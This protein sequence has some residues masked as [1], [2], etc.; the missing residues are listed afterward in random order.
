MYPNKP[1]A[2]EGDSITL[3]ISNTQVLTNIEWFNS[4]ITI[5]GETKTSYIAKAN[6]DYSC[7]VVDFNGCKGKTTNTSLNFYPFPMPVI[8]QNPS[9]RELVSSIEIGNQWVNNGVKIN[10]AKGPIYR[11]T[12]S[13]KYYTLV[14]SDRGCVGKSNELTITLLFTGINSISSE[15]LI[16][17]PKSFW[18]F[19]IKISPE[20]IENSHYKILDAQ[21][22]SMNQVICLN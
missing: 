15:D 11:P 5:A 1:F 6:G 8:S 3:S 13:G 7:S 22:K 14:T 20:F 12:T 21:S 9:N 4:N 10:N 19:S 18:D 17:S 16:I 2:C